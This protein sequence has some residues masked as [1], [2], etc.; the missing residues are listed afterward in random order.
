[1]YEEGFTIQQQFAKRV[2]P[3]KPSFSADE[4]RVTPS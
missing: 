1:M 3:S 2:V 4:R